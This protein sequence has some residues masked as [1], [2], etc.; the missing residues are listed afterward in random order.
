MW[1]KTTEN[2]LFA[3]T[4]QFYASFVNFQFIKQVILV[5]LTACWRH[6]ASWRQLLN[7]R[8]LAIR[9]TNILIVVLSNWVCN[10]SFFEANVI[11]CHN[12]VWE[13]S[14]ELSTAQMLQICCCM[15]R[16]INKAI[17]VSINFEKRSTASQ[18]LTGSRNA[19]LKNTD[20]RKS[21]G[22]P[23]PTCPRKK[24]LKVV[25]LHIQR[26]DNTVLILWFGTEVW[27]DLSVLPTCINS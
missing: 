2:F 10:S 7:T 3:D 13:Y 26:V 5:V 22:W 16:K 24:C 23:F 15:R 11:W 27:V 18:L 6:Q 17:I 9:Q 14:P 19:P 12:F 25:P 1:S 4:F 20:F 21:M 8:T